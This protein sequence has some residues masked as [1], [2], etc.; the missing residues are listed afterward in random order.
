MP[1]QNLVEFFLYIIPGYLAIRIYRWL[2]PVKDKD[3]FQD[4]AS[5]VLLGVSIISVLKWL[6]KKCFN[7]FLGS[8]NLGLPGMK[9]LLI[10]LIT[11]SVVGFSLFGCRELLKCLSKKPKWPRWLSFSENM[12]WEK[13]NA[14][15][16]YDWAVVYLDDG[17]IYY[18]W[19]SSFN[20]NPNN[21]DQDF[22]LSK[23]LRIDS[24]FNTLYEVSGIGVYLNTMNIKRI[25]Y[26]NS[27]AIDS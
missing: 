24:D 22:L 4:I 27:E 13:I 9:Y 10:I 15:D 7:F 12:V 19:I 16:N 20:Y 14:N 18:G 17:S 11:G 23:A 1:T 21:Q 26:I 6:D 5:S 3:S 2:T 8:N 25:E